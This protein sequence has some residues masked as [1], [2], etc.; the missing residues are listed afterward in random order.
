MKTVRIGLV[1]D[2]NERVRAHGAIPRAL[3]GAG[4]VAGV[5]VEHSW[6]PT[7]QLASGAAEALKPLQGIWCTPGSPYASMEGALAAVR[8]A[9]ECQMPLLGTCGGFQHALIEVARDVAG[10]A[11][12]DHQESSPDTAEPLIHRL[13]C[14]LRED[15]RAVHLLPGSTLAAIYERTEVREG[16]HCSFGLNPKYRL[17]LEAAGVRFIATDDDGEVRAMELAGHPFFL[18]MLF[19]VELSAL[20]GLVPPVAVAFVRAALAYGVGETGRQQR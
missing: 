3:D 17:A 2:R 10:I 7:A 4:R 13:A 15:E 6:L 11:G 5:A 1:G 19:Q 14:A 9:R 20:R 16:Y 8:F 12:A 18:A